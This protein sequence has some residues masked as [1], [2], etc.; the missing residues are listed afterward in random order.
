MLKK[1]PFGKSKETDFKT[2]KGQIVLLSPAAAELGCI[3]STN[4]TT[5]GTLG[6]KVQI[7]PLVI[8]GWSLKL[9][10]CSTLQLLKALLED[11]LRHAMINMHF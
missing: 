7:T 1:A 8:C 3:L 4:I 2:L 5:S 11:P 9:I 10:N 6:H